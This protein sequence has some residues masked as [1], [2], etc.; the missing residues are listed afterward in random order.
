MTLLFFAQC[1]DWAGTRRMELDEAGPVTLADLVEKRPALAFLKGR[2]DFVKVAV[3]Q[4]LA[5]WDMEVSH[6]DDI[7][8][9]PPFSGG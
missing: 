8:V 2:T 7:A 4:R 3:N 1:A 5:T 9:M 6:G